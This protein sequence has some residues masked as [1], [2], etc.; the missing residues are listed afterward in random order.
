MTRERELLMGCS[1]HMIEW[2]CI[3]S[4]NTSIPL[5]KNKLISGKAAKEFSN[6]RLGKDWYS[7]KINEDC[8]TLKIQALLALGLL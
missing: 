4:I 5:V 7:I 1:C 8:V 2:F 3:A 6:Y